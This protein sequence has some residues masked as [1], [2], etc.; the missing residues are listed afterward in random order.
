MPGAGGARAP[1]PGSL[2][3]TLRRAAHELGLPGL[4]GHSSVTGSGF[5]AQFSKSLSLSLCHPRVTGD[6]ADLRSVGQNDTGWTL[7]F[8][9]EHLGNQS[10][11][12]RP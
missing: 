7:S 8:I 2:H 5:S 10:P 12:P 11:D 9:T 4:G 6:I 1:H 3:P